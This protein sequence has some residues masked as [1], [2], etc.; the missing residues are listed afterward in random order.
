MLFARID[1]NWPFNEFEMKYDKQQENDF[2]IEL[3]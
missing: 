2:F 1:M 3:S